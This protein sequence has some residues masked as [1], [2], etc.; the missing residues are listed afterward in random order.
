MNE[1]KLYRQNKSRSK[2][3]KLALI[4]IAVYTMS[5]G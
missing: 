2:E 5:I 3:G 1:L 4:I